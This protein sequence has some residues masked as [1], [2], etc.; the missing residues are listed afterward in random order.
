MTSAVLGRLENEVH[1]FQFNS[2]GTLAGVQTPDVD[3]SFK[4]DEMGNRVYKK[5][6]STSN[7]VNESFYLFNLFSMT[8]GVINNHISDGTHVV[9]TKLR[10]DEEQV[11]YFTPD[12]LGSTVFVTDKAGTVL[13]KSMYDPFGN[14]FFEEDLNGTSVENER[15]FTNQIYD[16]ETGLYYFNARYYDPEN[17]VFISPDPAMDGLNHYVYARGN[18]L[19]FS[20]PTGLWGYDTGAGYDSYGYS[21]DGSYGYYA[22]Y[23]ASGNYGGYSSGYYEFQPGSYEL[24][25][26]EE[27]YSGGGHSGNVHVSFDV[28]TNLGTPDF[29]QKVRAS[30]YIGMTPSGFII[31][32]NRLTAQQYDQWREKHYNRNQG[33][34]RPSYEDAKAN[35]TQLNNFESAFHRYGEGNELNEKFISLDGHSEAVFHFGALVT[36]ELNGGTYNF[37]SP[38]THP[39]DHLFV[40]VAPYYWWGNGPN[41]PTTMGGRMWQNVIALEYKFLDWGIEF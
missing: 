8:N 35:W 28:D 38:I 13:S 1:E 33:M 11:L 24:V 29:S 25:V 14:A 32:P 4:Y 9:A 30:Y 5:S 3:V 27:F 10:N 31:S 16:E 20:D 41:D 12:H 26:G 18:P 19:L 23:D 39:G 17:G 34:V 37:Y 22:G 2:D 7:V 36:D 6:V 21:G 15:K 40:D